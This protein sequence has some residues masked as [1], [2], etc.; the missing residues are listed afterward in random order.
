MID[1]HT[2]T[3]LSDGELIPSELI[4]RAEMIGYQAIAIT[5][6]ADIS[7]YDFIIPRIIKVCEAMNRTK[8][9]ISLPG[10]ELTHVM[11]DDIP[12]LAK[13]ARDM[14]ARIIIVH[15]E[16]IVEPVAAGT[17]SKALESDIDI[18][19]HPG[20]I[21]ELEVKVAAQKG[22]CLELTSRHGHSFTNGHVARLAKKYGALLVLNTDTH[23]PHDLIGY[24]KAQKI[25]CGAGLTNNEFIELLNNSRKL[26]SK[27]V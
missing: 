16:T 7:N 8:K 13:E 24:E 9:L 27:A 3:F 5:D 1:L 14:G 4:R 21:S 10:I 26:V 2:H 15:G 20:L 17:N 22:I 23:S 11:P 12:F 19:A 6:H 25:A 18:L